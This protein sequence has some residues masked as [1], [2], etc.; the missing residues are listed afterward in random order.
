MSISTALQNTTTTRWDL[1]LHI[2]MCDATLSD[3]P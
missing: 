3:A 1:T 2:P